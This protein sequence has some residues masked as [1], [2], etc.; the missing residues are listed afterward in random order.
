M[1]VTYEVDGKIYS[2]ELD[3]SKILESIDTTKIDFSNI[4]FINWNTSFDIPITLPTGFGDGGFVG[5]DIHYNNTLNAISYLGNMSKSETKEDF[6]RWY[7]KFHETINNELIY[8]TNVLT[9]LIEQF[10]NEYGTITP[11]ISQKV[12]EVV[13]VANTTKKLLEGFASMATVVAVLSKI[14]VV[15]IPIGVILS[16]FQI[17]D[18]VISDSFKA[19][20]EQDILKQAQKVQNLIEAYQSNALYESLNR[21][22]TYVPKKATSSQQ[23]VTYVWIIIIVLLALIVYKKYKNG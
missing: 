6:D 10:K 11:S 21:F 14:T 17:L 18:T 1:T 16:T 15:L 20:K 7:E 13:N 22:E 2:Y 9:K 8:E 4:K 3:D 19:K 23:T 5:F 12:D